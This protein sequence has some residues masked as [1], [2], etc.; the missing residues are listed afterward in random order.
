MTN[1]NYEATYWSLEALA[2]KSSSSESTAVIELMAFLHGLRRAMEKDERGRK[3]VGENLVKIRQRCKLLYHFM[4]Y[5]K[6][7]RNQQRKIYGK[8]QSPQAN[9][10][11]SYRNELI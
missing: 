9:L 2:T 1:E 8:Y 7:N 6:K 5:P 11:T 3:S 4:S 10:A